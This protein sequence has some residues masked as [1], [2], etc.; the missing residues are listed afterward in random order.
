[1][2]GDLV[3]SLVYSDVDH[4]GLADVWWCHLPSGTTG[5]AGTGSRGGEG[6]DLPELCGTAPLVVNRD[7]FDMAITEDHA[8]THL[9][10]RW[11]E[12]DGQVGELDVTV[13]LPPGHESLNVVIPW[14]DETFNFTSKH[15]ARP[16]TGRLVVGGE[17]TEIGGAAGDAW[18]VLD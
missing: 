18:G 6:F 17:L 16:A 2:A 1:L 15:Q 8:G 13:A 7:G 12:R 14:D 3:V 9:A 5:G 10:A 4:L 11:T